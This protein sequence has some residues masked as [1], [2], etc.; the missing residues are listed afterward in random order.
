MKLDAPTIETIANLTTDG[1]V[2]TS[3]GDGTLST[4]AAAPASL[5]DPC[6]RARAEN[7]N[8]QFVGGDYT[9]GVKFGVRTP[10]SVLG[11]RFCIYDQGQTVRCRLWSTAGVSLASVDVVCPN[12]GTWN[13]VAGVFASPYDISAKGTPTGVGDRFTASVWD[14]SSHYTNNVFAAN[15]SDDPAP[16]AVGYAYYID[17]FGGY[18]AGGDGFPN[19]FDFAGTRYPIDPI[20]KV[21]L[22]P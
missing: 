13:I 8:L 10:C 18:Y 22:I 9:L 11:V 16:G 6:F 19:N 1:A 20:L 15:Y 2:Q 4:T 7:R 14:Q 17:D 5:I 12:T 21:T 3:G